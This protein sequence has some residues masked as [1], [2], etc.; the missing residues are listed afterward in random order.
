M[1]K[2]KAELEAIMEMKKVKIKYNTDEVQ[3]AIE[4]RAV[5]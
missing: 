4:T 2:T 5:L 1:N 3:H